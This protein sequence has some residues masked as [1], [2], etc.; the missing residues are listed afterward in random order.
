MGEPT[1]IEAR[2]R[3]LMQAS[4]DG[5]A[6]AYRTLLRE[7]DGYLRRYFGR[8]LHGAAADAAG[9]LVQDTLMA[10]HSRR[11]T[12]D[13]R[14]PF[15]PWLYA[16]AR[17]KLADHFRRQRVTVP[18]DDEDSLFAADEEPDVT[19]RLDVDRMLGT[20][21]ERTRELI[22]RTRIDGAPV[23]EAAAAAGMTETAA[24]V[25]IHRGLKA[26][27]ARVGRRPEQ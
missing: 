2:L 24:K 27:M 23:A 18:I 17:Y 16:I 9:D 8:R 19:A 12:Y 3:P 7:V 6:A 25:S 1:A 13:R 15:T 10:L 14:Q 11:M 5:D 22:R 20:L 4:L 21:P 26:L